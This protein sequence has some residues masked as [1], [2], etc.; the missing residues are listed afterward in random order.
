VIANIVMPMDAWSL[1]GILIVVPAI[2]FLIAVAAASA[3]RMSREDAR[4]LMFAGI[5]LTPVALICGWLGKVASQPWD[6]IAHLA[7][8]FAGFVVAYAVIAALLRCIST[9]TVRAL[10]LVQ[11]RP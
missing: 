4:Q 11:K 3:V 6:T 5:V 9:V 7:G 2:L 1:A 8:D 10:N